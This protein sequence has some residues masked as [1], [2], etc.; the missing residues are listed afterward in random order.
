M[1]LKNPFTKAAIDNSIVAVPLLPSHWQVV[2]NK[3]KDNKLVWSFNAT[4]NRGATP[5]VRITYYISCITPK[6]F[7]RYACWL[8]LATKRDKC[9]AIH[10]SIQ[11][12]TRGG[13]LSSQAKTRLGGKLLTWPHTHWHLCFGSTFTIIDSNSSLLKSEPSKYLHGGKISK[14][15]KIYIFFCVKLVSF[16][17]FHHIS[18]NIMTD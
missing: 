10:S 3:F 11:M 6:D 14:K 7:R 4:G 8:F 5:Q 13:S 18:N 16:W 17:I 15:W 1:Q 9:V 12:E 2:R